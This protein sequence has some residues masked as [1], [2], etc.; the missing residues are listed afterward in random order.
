MLFGL[1]SCRQIIENETFSICR[2]KQNLERFVTK[3]L[4][5]FVNYFM[6]AMIISTMALSI[7]ALSIMALSIMRLS[8]MR[9]SIMKLSIM[10]FSIKD[11]KDNEDC[12]DDNQHQALLC[13]SCVFVWLC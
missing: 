6:G 1:L 13:K 12:L 8:I 9:L 7:M 10:K 4:F 2:Q 5:T 11:T 3:K